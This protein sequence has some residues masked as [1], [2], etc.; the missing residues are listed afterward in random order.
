[1]SPAPATPEPERAESPRPSPRQDSTRRTSLRPS[2]QTYIEQQRQKKLAEQAEKQRVLQLLENDKAERRVRERERRDSVIRTPTP[3][4]VNPR[5]EPWSDEVALSFRLT[6]GSNVKSRFPSSAVL[7]VDARGWIEQNRTDGDRPYNFMEILG[8]ARNRSLDI[9]DES[10]PLGQLFKCSATLVLVPTTTFTTGA[11]ESAA[12]AGVVSQAYGM[13]SGA[14]SAVWNLT[15]F[16]PRAD[17]DERQ[18]P[19][20][21]PPQTQGGSAQP[22]GGSSRNDRVRTL[23]DRSDENERRYY[24]GNQLSFEPKPGDNQG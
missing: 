1:V 5:P 8:P 21:P 17:S 4:N 6:D 7:G 3:N 24:N 2:G 22:G 23:H 12:R 9:S 10:V 18:G 15:T 20:P 19:P 14:F 13:I 16:S 11:Y